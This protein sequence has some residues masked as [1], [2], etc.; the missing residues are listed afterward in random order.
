MFKMSILFPTLTNKAK[1]KYEGASKQSPD[2]KNYNTPGP[3][4]MLQNSW[5]RH[6]LLS[7]LR[8]EHKESTRKTVQHTY[9]EIGM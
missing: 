3:R 5:I 6:C 8:F 1:G 4:P 7:D 2:L 9:V